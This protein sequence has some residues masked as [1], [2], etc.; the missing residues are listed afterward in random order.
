MSLKEQ[1][2]YI[3]HLR[4][5][6]VAAVSMIPG[7]GSPLSMLMDKYIPSYVEYRRNELLTKLAHDLQEL[8][9]R[10]TPERLA[11]EEF[12]SVFIKGFRRAMEEHLEEKLEAFR[13]I[14]LNSAI[15]QRSDFDELTLFLRLV[16]DL[17]VDQIRILKL[18]QNDEGIRKGSKGLFLVMR[19]AWPEADPDYLMACVN[20]LLRGN[21]VSSNP[22]DKKRQGQHLLTGLGKRFIAYISSPSVE[23]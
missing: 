8:N 15:S 13:F 18:L 20:E 10:I 21:L 11:S 12:A 3:E 16:S 9:D 4:N 6:S 22:K 19:E 2:K 23:K 5:I 1:E 14:I 17:T 7:L